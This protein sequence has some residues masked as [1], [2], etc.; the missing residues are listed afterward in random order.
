MIKKLIC[1]LALCTAQTSI[2]MQGLPTVPDDGQVWY[3]INEVKDLIPFADTAFAVRSN[4]NPRTWQPPYIIDDPDTFYGR[5]I[6]TTLINRNLERWDDYD[7]ILFRAEGIDENTC[8][9]LDKS[10]FSTYKH[11]ALFR[12]LT[13]SEMRQIFDPE[14]HPDSIKR[15]SDSTLRTHYCKLENL[16]PKEMRKYVLDHSGIVTLLGI[17]ARRES[18]LSMIHKDA[19]PILIKQLMALET[20][21]IGKEPLQLWT[22]KEKLPEKKE[23]VK[24]ASRC[25]IQ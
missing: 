25:G 22:P 14:R 16:T 23:P 6:K 1:A 3:A 17:R 15:Y 8:I 12:L 7:L 9:H 10:F 20:E 19:F 18:Q 24:E 13:V 4:Y 11:R 5:I 21:R 2:C